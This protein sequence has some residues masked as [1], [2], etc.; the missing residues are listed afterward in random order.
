VKRLPYILLMP[1][2]MLSA[3]GPRLS[4]CLRADVFCVGLVT[5]SGS[6]DGGINQQVWLGLQDARAQGLVDRIDVIQTVE[7]RDRAAN[8]QVLVS[9]GY[10]LIVTV[11][12]PIA[13]Q[14]YAAAQANPRIFFIAVG[15]DQPND[16][17]N[18]SVL[19]FHEEQSGFLAGALAALTTQTNRV[20][21][22]CDSRSSG[23]MRRYCDGFQAGAQSI[24]PG[25]T[26]TIAYRDGPP[27]L[28]FN[29]P[30]WG[31]GTG[32]ALVADGADVVF[33]AGGDTGTAVLEAASNAGADV[34]AAETDPYDGLPSIRPHLLSAAVDEIRQGLLDMLRAARAGKLSGGNFFGPGGLAPFHDLN[35]ELPLNVKARL[36]TLESGLADGSL[37]VPVP[38]QS[39]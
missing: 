17:P 36:G 18:L 30:D 29:D 3:C 1:A 31:T 9:D 2:L 22:A 21:A 14:T 25:I 16:L 7:A 34:I 5:A 10:D 24:N 6:I 23:E 19:A 39:P 8:I 13:A 12:L 35:D 27:D 37:V 26:L 32:A 15:Q 28:L 11:G 38:Y 20:A 4:D 33:A